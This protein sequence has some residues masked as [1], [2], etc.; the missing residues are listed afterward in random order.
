MK[1]RNLLVAW[2]AIGFLMFGLTMALH[3]KAREKGF[4]ASQSCVIAV[5]QAGFTAG[6]AG[7]ACR[8]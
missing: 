3:L 2:L 7:E 1:E 4:P 6:Q 8:G 5:K